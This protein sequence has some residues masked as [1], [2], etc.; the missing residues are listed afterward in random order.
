MT[1][2]ET[3]F[4]KVAKKNSEFNFKE[5]LYGTV[6]GS[7]AAVLTQPIDT[8]AALGQN[9]NLSI[10]QTVSKINQDV[11]S[12]LPHNIGRSGR[13]A[14]L[15]ARYFA[16]IAPKLLKIGPATGLSWAIANNLKERFE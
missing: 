11:I 10:A 14:A 2:A 16:G 4:E 12:K 9:N 3:V 5:F 7:A 13:V 6:G 8:I 15:T 1:K